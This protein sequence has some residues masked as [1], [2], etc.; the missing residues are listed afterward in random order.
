MEKEAQE[1]IRIVFVG[2]GGSIHTA[3]WISQL[4]DTTWEIFL[5]P[6]EIYH[7]REEMPA[8]TIT[9]VQDPGRVSGPQHLRLRDWFYSAWGW[10]WPFSFGRWRVMS[11]VGR[12]QP[13]FYEPAW[14][15]ARL[16]DRVRPDIVHS[17]GLHLGGYL[18]YAARQYCRRPFPTWIA[19]NWGSDLFLFGRLSDHK[20]RLNQVISNID[21]YW[22]EC[23]RD[24][25]LAKHWGV[26]QEKILPP[27]P[28]AGGFDLSRAMALREPTPTASR[29]FI[30]VKGY[31]DWAGR[32]LVALHALRLCSEFLRPYQIA[33]YT[34]GRDPE[35]VQIAAELLSQDTGV[36]VVFI[37]PRTSHENMLRW[38]SR[39]RISIGLS[40]S[41]SI[42]ISLLEAMLM[43]AFPIQSNTGAAS[44][45]IEDG[46]TGFIVPPEDPYAV[47]D[48]IRRALSDDELVN[49]AA[50]MNFH[51]IQ[52]RCDSRLIGEIVRSVYRQIANRSV[53]QCCNGQTTKPLEI[54]YP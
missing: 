21:Y 12:I 50:E 45:W 33:I 6:T 28:V 9:D 2:P 34:G 31:Q 24:V 35:P 30:V 17:F 18:T 47:A 5:F 1:R 54:A 51:T 11:W 3:R 40:I 8:I 10:N 37:P 15:L 25:E 20:E 14:R 43:G 19:T 44:E 16:L 42:A 39:A 26:P 7:V 49:S 29:R 48:A 36:P 4:T 13:R 32:A 27:V 53:L 52:S 22:C 41:D 23:S 38:H 46:K